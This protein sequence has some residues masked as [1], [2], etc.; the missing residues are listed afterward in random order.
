M[1]SVTVEIELDHGLFEWIK[2]YHEVFPV[3]TLEEQMVYMLRDGI[4]K[5][6]PKDGIG[7]PMRNL[8]NKRWPGGVNTD[9]NRERWME[10]M[11]FHHKWVD[12]VC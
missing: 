11:N 8:M 9:R 1:P 6:S 7:G 10:K 12:P 4:I 2:A 3:G 5:Y